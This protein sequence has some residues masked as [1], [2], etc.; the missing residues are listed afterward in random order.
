MLKVREGMGKE[1]VANMIERMV[2]FSDPD[3]YDIVEE[4]FNNYFKR[5]NNNIEI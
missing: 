3:V 5:I 2:G 4:Y 1:E